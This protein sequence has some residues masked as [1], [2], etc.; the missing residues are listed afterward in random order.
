[1]DSLSRAGESTGFG[2]A[3]H[4]SKLERA[5]QLVVPDGTLEA[6]KWIALISMTGD[7]VNK[8]L[9]NGT[10][11]WLFY[12]GRSAL[13]LFVFVLAY[14]LARP[15]AK[16]RGAYHRTIWRLVV[17]GGLTTPVFIGLGGLVAGWW[18]LNIMF[19]LAAVAV[20]LLLAERRTVA[21]YVCAAGVSLA[22]GALVEFGWSALALGLAVWIYCWRRSWMAMALA[23]AAFAGLWHVNGN[24]WALVAVP[25][26]L[27][28]SGVG[29]NVSRL[30]WVFYA[31]Y[32][33]H[34]FVLWLIR[35][36]MSKAGYL[37]F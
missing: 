19:T 17:V 29:L 31:Y 4:R 3:G 1:M 20:M 26:V 8:Y 36:P 7:H 35:I 27:G 24:P 22:A 16:V 32:P 9:F 12:C 11:D 14:N 21:G 6:F 30:R 25:I 10:H 23:A 13:P 2:A 18:P 28:A 15:G 34:L 37:F 33:A 5:P